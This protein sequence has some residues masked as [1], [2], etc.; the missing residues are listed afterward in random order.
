MLEELDHFE[1]MMRLQGRAAYEDQAEL[2]WRD[3]REEMI[4]RRK[5]P[6]KALLT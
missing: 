5:K 1:E 3:W 6:Q 2:D 4:K